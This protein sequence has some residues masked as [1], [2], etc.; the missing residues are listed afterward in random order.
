MVPITIVFM[1]FINHLTSLGGPT[2]QEIEGG[3]LKL[4]HA[5]ASGCHA[6]YSL[7]CREGVFEVKAASQAVDESGIDSPTD[8][9]MVQQIDMIFV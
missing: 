1:G 6:E 5:F 4:L 2:L 9:R 8:L 3:E 7:I